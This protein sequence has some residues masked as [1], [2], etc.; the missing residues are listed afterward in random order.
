MARISGSKR[1]QFAA[2]RADTVK[3]CQCQTTRWHFPSDGSTPRI[4]K[5]SIRARPADCLHWHQYQ[6]R[7]PH[8]DALRAQKLPGKPPKVT[9]YK[10]GLQARTVQ[11]SRVGWLV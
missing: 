9:R 8:P 5:S 3:A 4:Q 7:L 11:L 10:Q 2:D 1:R 6:D